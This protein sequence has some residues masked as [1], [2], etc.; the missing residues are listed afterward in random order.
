MATLSWTCDGQPKNV[1]QSIS[2]TTVTSVL[3]LTLQKGHN[4]IT[5]TCH[6]R[7]TDTRYTPNITIRTL[8][9]YYPPSAPG[10]YTSTSSPFPWI[11]AGNGTLECKS[12]PGNPSTITY[13]WIR[14]NVVIQGQTG[15]SLVITSLTRNDNRKSYKW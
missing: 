13:Q 8:I 11:E 14:E 3:T 7:H 9:V 6:G 4:G 12:Q 1:N 5:C 15:D 2:G 10:L